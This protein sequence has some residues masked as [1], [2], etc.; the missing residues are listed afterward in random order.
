M[1]LRGYR[2]RGFLLASALGLTVSACGGKPD[3][4]HLPAP[5]LALQADQ[6]DPRP[7]LPEGAES[8]EA[9]Y[10]A[11]VSDVMDWGERRDL[12]AQRWCTWANT[13][14]AEKVGC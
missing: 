12:Q 3:V 5:P 8:S 7:A 1:R 9:I 13:W 11:W 14:L 2:I 10:E 4:E 6:V